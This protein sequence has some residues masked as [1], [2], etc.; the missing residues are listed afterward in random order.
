MVGIIDGAIML[1]HVWHQVVSQIVAEHIVAKHSLRHT[2]HAHS[3]WGGQQ[4]VRVTVRQHHDHL[5]GLT[6]CQKVV[7]DIVHASHFIIHLLCV[8]RTADEIEH[9]V[10]LVLLLLVLRWQVDHSLIRG[11]E[12]LRI[13][14]DILHRA[15]G[16][17][18]DVVS[19]TAR[20][21]RNLQQRVLKA[22]VG[23]V[24]RVLWIHHAHPV[25]D[26]A[27]GVHVWCGRSDGGRPDALCILCHGVA[28][29]KLHVYQHLFRQIV[30]VLESHRS[31]LIADGRALGK[32]H[33]YPA[34]KQL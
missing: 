30:L 31:V 18:L 13:I 17:V 10:F 22:F 9:G 20:L 2:S 15:V 24:L 32:S 8:C 12:A 14:V 4:F 5:L 16:H 7:E 11:A 28:P 26:K 23:E 1:F 33:C 21:G 3:G 27:V 29:S 25:D 34:N 6:F 19:Q